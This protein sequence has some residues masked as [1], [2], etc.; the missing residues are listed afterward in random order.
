MKIVR[1]IIGGVVFGILGEIFGWLIYGACFKDAVT[2]VS[3][4]WRPMDSLYW[5]VGMP[6]VDIFAGLMIALGF[7][8]FYKGIP[9]EGIKK[10]LVFGLIL[11]LMSRV[12]GELFWYVMSPIPFSLVIAGW[13]HGILVAAIGGMVLAAIYGKS[14]E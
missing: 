10:G 8:L 3:Q 12:P 13:I 2:A 6:L 5:R 4:F 14:L 9:G 1:G 7:A 11:W